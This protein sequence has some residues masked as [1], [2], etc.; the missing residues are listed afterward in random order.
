MAKFNAET[1]IW[2]ATSVAY[3]YSMDT[4]LGE[5]ILNSCNETP[6]RVIQIHHE[7][8]SSLRC[9]ELKV[10]SIKI[11]QNLIAIGIKP[12]DVIGLIC[13]NSNFVTCFLTGSILMGGIVHPL[14]HSLSAD[15]MSQLYG[16]SQ[17]KL[18]ICD[19][20]NLSSLQDALGKINI[21]PMIY[22]TEKDGDEEEGFP[23]AFDLLN[24]SGDV[25]KFVTPKFN[26][27]AD[28]KLCAILCS[29]GVTG[30]QKGV[31][32]S[33][34]TCLR[35]DFK[36][37]PKPPSR[38]LTFSSAYWSSGFFLHIFAAFYPNDIRIWS[39]DDFNVDKLVEIID[40]HKISGINLAPSSLAA[41]LN[42]DFFISSNHECC[43]TFVVIGSMFSDSLRQKFRK[44]FPTK[45][46]M[47]GYGM[48]E[49]FISLSKPNECYRGM[50]VGSMI[51]PNLR[52][53]IVN[54][55]GESVNP[56]EY[57]EI[58]VKTQFK[59]LVSRFE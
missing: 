38:P 21:K 3:P 19:L 49:V 42:S 12:D 57:G 16:H 44:T 15:N 2:E 55:K 45:L 52:L 28:K 26:Q 4:F 8:E 10:S 13:R 39:S 58:R 23:S 5:V 29:S 18:I 37:Y 48:T 47:T 46:L 41:L 35:F 30:L 53:K 34:A 36:S 27:S 59:F 33:H 9:H 1:K 24:S 32:I 17:P 40:A 22:V 54:K 50:T 56:G 31:C 43:S 51:T 25:E 20:E 6:N 14:D 7:E 11:A